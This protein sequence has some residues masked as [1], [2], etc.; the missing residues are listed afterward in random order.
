MALNSD[1][2]E[3]PAVQSW[4]QLGRT[5]PRGIEV[6]ESRELATK[7]RTV[8]RLLGV[9]LGG[10]S[11]IAKQ[12]AL[13]A[14]YHTECLVSERFLRQGPLNRLTFYGTVEEE[15]TLFAW[16]FLENAEVDHYSPQRGD[17][18]VFAGWWLDILRTRGGQWG[19]VGS[20]LECD[21]YPSPG[22]IDTARDPI[23]RAILSARF[24][25]NA[26]SRDYGYGMG[27]TSGSFS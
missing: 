8:Y 20:P 13:N 16:L 12:R 3:H 9:G 4:H 18:R 15:E 26:W 6:I 25:S 1:T 23:L 7:G 5:T 11:V 24:Q 27:L 2:T 19:S 10:I 22:L 21:P 14:T 17:H